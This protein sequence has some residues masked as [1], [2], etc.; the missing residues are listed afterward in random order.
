MYVSRTDAGDLWSGAGALTLPD[1][2]E[3]LAAFCGHIGDQPDDHPVTRW[4]HTL[5]LVHLTAREQPLRDD[6]FDWDREELIARIDGW[7]ADRTARPAS[8]SLG[9][10]IDGMAAAQVRATW[11]L[12]NADDI[13]D[14]QVHA[15]W[16]LLASL[17]DGWTD[18][19]AETVGHAGAWRHS[20]S[21]LGDTL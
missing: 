10:A 12:R 13:A 15:A 21:L 16:F 11:L 1:W 20:S 7:V 6:E 3:L 2:H 8:T 5:A 9:A 19:V 4:A 14:E 18:L 17:A